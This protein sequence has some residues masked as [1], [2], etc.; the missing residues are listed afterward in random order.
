MPPYYPYINQTPNELRSQLSSG[1]LSVGVDSMTVAIPSPKN[2]SLSGWQTKSFSRTHTRIGRSIVPMVANVRNGPALSMTYIDSPHQVATYL[3][4]NP[5]RV[6]DPWGTNLATVDE[7]KSLLTDVVFPLLPAWVPSPSLDGADLYRLDLAVD[8]ETGPHSQQ[9]LRDCEV[10]LYRPQHHTYIYLNGPGRVGT[11]G[12]KSVT[13]PRVS[14]YDKGAESKTPPERL[15]FEV[16]FR[17][18]ALRAGFPSGLAE[19]SE[20]SARQQFQHELGDVARTSSNRSPRIVDLSLSDA[21]MK[22]FY[23]MLGRSTAEKLG[24]LRPAPPSAQR[25]HKKF[26]TTFD[27]SSIEELLEGE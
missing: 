11:I 22:T 10:P 3:R 27:I 26:L 17:R 25:R 20:A 21:D 6:L 5:S 16:Q 4:F 7:A 24:A 18:S 8:I 1:D 13:R 15:R 19:L 14:I 12:R 9:V 23:E 2:A